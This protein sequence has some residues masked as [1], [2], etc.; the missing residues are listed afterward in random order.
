[1]MSMRLAPLAVAVLI[2]ACSDSGTSDSASKGVGGSY[3]FVS[4]P[5]IYYG[6][7][8]VGSSSEEVLEIQNR[9]A[10]R[11]SLESIRM[12]GDNPDSFVA[13]ILD[14]VLL[15]PAQAL[16]IPIA[17]EPLSEGRKTASFEVDF[18]T[19]QL[20]DESVNVQE[21]AYYEASDLAA[22]GRYRA[23]AERYEDYL[24]SDP[25]T[26][27]K[28]RAA[29]RIPVVQEAELYGDGRDSTLYLDALA[30]RERSDPE[31]ALHALDTLIVLESDSYLADDAQYLK[32]YIALQDLNDPALALREF[33]TLTD[34]HPDSTYY[35]T[36]QYG[37][38]L[39][40]QE[41]GNDRLASVL[42]EDLK[43]RHTGISA[44]G[45][46]LP[47]DDLVSRLWFARAS[48]ALESLGGVDASV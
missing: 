37:A 39:A 33:Q 2:S 26:V 29:V 22:D 27:N 30:A 14:D 21:Q 16:R 38:A 28:R 12:V 6:A 5:E 48:T 46:D 13:P 1:M 47:K 3:L 45:V 35:D 23:S 20:V 31:D 4:I 42:L 32:A 44:L 7:R 19:I 17:F 11:Y 25:V 41:L 18:T 43:S 34:T 8:S 40:Q 24:K 10:D 9:A 36:A 15:E